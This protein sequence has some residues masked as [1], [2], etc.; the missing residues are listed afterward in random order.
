MSIIC[1]GETYD[2]CVSVAEDIIRRTCSKYM[3]IKNSGH[4]LARRKL[5][6]SLISNRLND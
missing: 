4:N 5:I 1:L 3:E 6:S 2:Y